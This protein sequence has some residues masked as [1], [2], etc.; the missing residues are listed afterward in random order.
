[1]NMKF[2]SSL[3][4][5]RI[6]SSFSLT[7]THIHILFLSGFISRQS[8]LLI[9]SIKFIRDGFVRV[10]VLYSSASSPPTGYE[11]ILLILILNIARIIECSL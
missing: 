11:I 2:S 1:M 4:L 7:H 10:I 8:F 9:K 5:S 6:L 3:S